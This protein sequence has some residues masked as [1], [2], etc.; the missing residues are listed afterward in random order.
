MPQ[1]GSWLSR[2]IV[3]IFGIGILGPFIILLSTSFKS[4]AEVFQNPVSLPQHPNLDNYLYVLQN[5]NMPLYFRNS[6]VVSLAANVT[7][8]ILATL[9]SYAIVR[10][11]GWLG[12][13]IFGVFTFG[14]TIPVQANMVPLYLIMVKLHLLD[15]L[16]GLILVYITFAMP[17][18]IFVISGFMRTIPVALLEAAKIDGATEFHT[19]R[20]IVMP[21]TIPSLVTVFIFNF[22]S[23]WNDLTW[24]LLFVRADNAK[25]L[26]IALLR[27]QGEFTTNYPV[28]FS[29]V[30]MAV[31]PM[32]I[33][34]LFLQRYFVEGL[35]VGAVKG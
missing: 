8:I 2:L 12:T 23:I 18:S 11:T 7:I 15:S 6:I 29:G 17:F 26:P 10:T 24:P 9:A 25:T 1:K 28:L 30:I 16:V 5:S 22:V 14:M 21:L 34:Y 19:L 4:T 20:K 27:F 31:L 3:L 35:T 32:L 13:L 33:L